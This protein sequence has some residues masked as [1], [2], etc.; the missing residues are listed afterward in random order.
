MHKPSWLEKRIDLKSCHD[1]KYLLGR[2]R[3]TTVC[4]QASCPNISE[5]FSKGIATFLI[6]GRICTRNCLFC[7]VFKGNPS[8]VDQTEPM[9]LRMAVTQMKLD[10]V[11]ITSPTRDDLADK[12]AEAYFCTINE[13]NN[14]SPLMKIEVL[15]PDF[16]MDRQAIA[17]VLSAHPDI[18]AHN[19]ETVPSLYKEIRSQADY[20]RSLDVLR[21][22]THFDNNIRAKS[23]IMLGLGERSEEVIQ[24]LKDLRGV[25]CELLSIGQYLSPSRGH[26]PVKE[27]VSLEQFAYY[28]E[29]ALSLGFKKVMS[30]P[31]VRSS[32]LAHTYFK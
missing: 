14:I 23:G 5:C 15:I 8:P 20:R 3:I 12:G 22:I 4:E 11:V 19:I 16:L 13:L 25:G 29:R 30:G 24:V 2:L 27:Y 17:R 21:F 10:Y 31:Y 18:V 9:R 28:K 32:Y 1:M 7:D 6:L 26:Y